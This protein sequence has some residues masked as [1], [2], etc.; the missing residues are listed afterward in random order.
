M[1]SFDLKLAMHALKLG[2][3]RDTNASDLNG[4]RNYIIE[5]AKI[6]SLHKVLTLNLL[7]EKTFA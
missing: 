7:K 6:I 2:L 3:V 5:G 1:F 4:T